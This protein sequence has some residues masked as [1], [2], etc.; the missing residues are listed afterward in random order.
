MVNG[1]TTGGAGGPTVIVTNGSDFVAQVGMAGPRIIQV[2]G[3]L[4]IDTA[5]VS[6]SKT[7]LGLSTNATLL[8]RLSISGVTNVIVRNLRITNPGNDGISIRDPNTHHVWVDHVTFYDCGDGSCDISQEAN[9]V[10]V[11]WCKFFYPT[12][13]EHR[14]VMIGSGISNV[15]PSITLHHNWWGARADQ[16]MSASGDAIVHMY[17]NYFNCTNNSYC[18][19]ARDRTEINSENNYYSG[20]KD[21]IYVSAGILDGKIRTSGNIYVGCTGQIDPGTDSVFTPPYSYTLDPTANVPAIVM[22]GAGAP[23]PETIPIPPK[24]WDGGGANNSLNTVNNWGFGGGYNEAPKPHDALLF[25]GNTRLT[26]NNNYT[27]NTEFTALNFGNTASAFILSGNALRLGKGITNDSTVVQ[28]ISLSLDFAYAADHFPTNRYVIVG[29]TNGSLVING[30]IAGATNGY[31][32]IY[33]ITKLG[34]GLLTLAGINTFAANLN[35]NGGLVRFSTLNTGLAGSLGIVNRINLDGGGLQ[36][37]A[38]N[39]ADISTR[40]VTIL[41]GGA[42][43]D[44]G[45]NNITFANAIGNNGAGA[46]TKT[47][48]GTLTLNGNNNY[49]SNTLI[50]QGVLALG[51]AGAL[52]NSARIILSNNATLDVFARSD[53]TLTLGNGKF[54]VGN[55]TVRGSVIAA[56]GAT[57]TSGFSIG[58]LVVTNTLT[59]QLS[60]TNLMELDATTHT[61]DFITGMV[62]VN[63]GGRL[64]V[65]NLGGTLAAGD[66]F[67]LFNAGSYSGAFTSL[68]LPALTGNLFWTNRLGLDGTI[69]VVSPV[70]TAPTNITVAVVGNSLQLS[71]PADHIGW[72]LEVQTNSLTVGFGNNWVTVPGSPDTNLIWFPKS[73]ANGSVFYRLVYP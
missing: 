26:P 46:L 12:Q 55:G 23:G 48:S 7:I 13:L 32:R 65:M 1:T 10:T 5:N 28:T 3:V 70:N 61:N 52:P 47:G 18:S 68:T 27:A 38:G 58:T 50:S 67:K 56:S 62:R 21:P 19:N 30:N 71:W 31:G 6:S 24:I 20:V 63:Y 4:T 49:S 9:Y 15:P 66:S 51:V 45:A 17:N 35:L 2:D 22:A 33:S 72:R 53:G 44:V 40:T 14:F 37:A 39:T 8:G 60:S 29:A 64:I 16:R 73:F 34:P 41:S 11:S 69:A 36:W 57:I 25:A 43:L 54:L 42:T 59:F